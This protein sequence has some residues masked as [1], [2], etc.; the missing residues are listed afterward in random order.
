[1]AFDTRLGLQFPRFSFDGLE[2]ADIFERVSAAAVTAEGCGFDSIYV[3]DH[4]WQL[5]MIGPP[6]LPMLEGYTLLGALA[7]RTKTARLGTLVTG[8]TY[9]NPAIL[10]KEVT[11]LDAISGGRAILGIGAAWYEEEHRGLG[12]D[13]PPMRERFERLEEALQICIAMFTEE[14]P[15]FAGTHYRIEGAINSPRPLSP[16]GIPVLIGG[17]GEKRTLRLVAQ[18][19]DACNLIS[20]IAEIPHKLE[21]LDGHLADLGRDRSEVTRTWLGS[22]VVGTDHD[23]AMARLDGLLVPRGIDHSLYE[24]PATRGSLFGRMIA[25]GPDEVGERV[26]ELYAMGLDGLVFNL[27]ADGLDP[28]AV[29]LAGSTLSPL[30]PA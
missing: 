30:V 17:A 16:G 26:A 10:A 19:G 6:E 21:V 24:D 7:A 5:A 11:T 23:D 18:Y 14:A 8:V 25:G 20:D 28:D 3:M 27:P 2:P 15:S 29:A 12:V 13:F 4:F 1:M 9:R 22:L